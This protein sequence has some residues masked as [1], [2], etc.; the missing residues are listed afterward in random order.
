[1]NL[2]NSHG[3]AFSDTLVKPKFT[4]YKDDRGHNKDKTHI[5]ISTKTELYYYKYYCD[6][7]R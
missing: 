2:H 5:E 4:R 3:K 1:M 7:H 6:I